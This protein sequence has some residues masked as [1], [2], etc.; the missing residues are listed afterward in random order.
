MVSNFTSRDSRLTNMLGQLQL[1]YQ[2]TLPELTQQ[3][4]GEFVIIMEV[5]VLCSYRSGT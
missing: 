3:Y 5:Y 1:Y 2:Q 4:T